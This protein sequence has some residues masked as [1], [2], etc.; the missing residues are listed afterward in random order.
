[1]D[2]APTRRP[3]T[4]PALVPSTQAAEPVAKWLEGKFRQGVD[5][6]IRSAHDANLPVAI[7]GDDGRLAWLH[8]DGIVRPT[9]DTG[10]VNGPG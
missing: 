10:D 4:R 8:P 1:M 7:L 2:S 9:R 5:Q 6:A 3:E